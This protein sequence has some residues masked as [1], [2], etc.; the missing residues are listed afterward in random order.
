M[1]LLYLSLAGDA[2]ARPFSHACGSS[3]TNPHSTRTTVVRLWLDEGD[4]RSHWS[5]IVRSNG[6]AWTALG[7]FGVC[8]DGIIDNH[9]VIEIL[10]PSFSSG[11]AQCFGLGYASCARTFTITSLVTAFCSL[12]SAWSMGFC[13]CQLVYHPL[14]RLQWCTC[15]FR[16]TPVCFA[17]NISIG[18]RQLRK[19]R[20]R[21]A[22]YDMDLPAQLYPRPL[23]N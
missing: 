10:Q 18:Q 8:V 22:S 14:P 20:E 4:C 21:L 3:P 16:R 15:R 11:Q 19:S 1:G 5:V 7:R 23:S 12:I 6:C 13:C 2:Y 9:R 17:S